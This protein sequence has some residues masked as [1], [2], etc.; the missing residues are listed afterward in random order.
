MSPA[1]IGCKPPI[2][3]VG[4]FFSH[5]TKN[6]GKRQ[7]QEVDDWVT[8]VKFLNISRFKILWAWYFRVRVRHCAEV[9]TWLWCMV[10]ASHRCML[11]IVA[12]CCPKM[13]PCHCE[14]SVDGSW[15]IFPVS[16]NILAVFLYF[17]VFIEPN[18]QAK[19]KSTRCTSRELISFHI[20]LNYSS[21]AKLKN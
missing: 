2:N 7:G 21:H 14:C 1:E 11:F 13:I 4:K 5:A 16:F 10:N 8:K 19:S 12:H 6:H 18:L 17:H 3:V 9:F 20:K 15:F